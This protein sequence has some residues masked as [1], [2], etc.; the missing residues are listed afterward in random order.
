MEAKYRLITLGCKVNQY[1]TQVVR[2]VLEATGLRAARPGEDADWAIINTCAVTG[3]ALRKSRQAVRRALRDGAARVM[4]IGCGADAD[5]E[6]L[7]SIEG[8][9]A[10][11][12]H[13]EEIRSRVREIVLARL[14]PGSR[15]TTACPS[16]L[17]L[18]RLPAGQI[19]GCKPVPHPA[20]D[21]NEGSIRPMVPTSA[22]GPTADSSDPRVN[23][24]ITR[25][26]PIVKRADEL[27]AQIARFEGRRRAFLKV[28]DGCDAFCSYC[29]IPR[30]RPNLRWKRIDVAVAEAEALVR[31]GHREI[32]LTGV[33]LGAYGRDTAIRKRFQPGPSPLAG[34]V[35]ALA[36]VKGLER[37]R[38]SSLE[39]GDV[40]Q[41]LLDALALH[42]NCVPHLHLPLQSGSPNILRRMN[43]QYSVD[44]FVE[45][46]DR[47]RAALDRPA[48][49]T[50]IIVG[51][52]G[53][54]EAD[55]EATLKVVRHA[56]VCKI[57]TFPFSPR[58]KTA[59]ARWTNEFVPPATV[60]ERLRRLA[61]V[62]AELS[63]AFR[64]QFIGCI[65][66]VIVES[67]AS[68]PRVGRPVA[69]DL[70]VGRADRYFEIHFEAD[71]VSPGDL[72]HVR[73]DRVTS[74]GCHGRLVRPCC[75]APDAL[76]DEPPVAPRRPVIGRALGAIVRSL[77]VAVLLAAPARA[78]ELY[79]AQ[80]GVIEGRVIEETP[81]ALRVETTTGV[82]DVPPG[83][84][85]RRVYGPSR[86]ERYRSLEAAVAEDGFTAA[87]HIEIARWCRENRLE[88]AFREQVAAALKLEPA[89]PEARRLAGYVLLGDVWLKTTPS[90]RDNTIRAGL[91]PVR[92]KDDAH[93][94]EQL[95]AGWYR[96]VRT[97]HDTFLSGSDR[98]ARQTATGRE[99]LL[100][101][102]SPLA[103]P[104]TCRF[105]GAG[106]TST[107]LLLIEFLGAFEED[108]A[109]LNLFALALLDDEPRVRLAAV[110]QL[111]RR[112][113]TGEDTGFKPVPHLRALNLLRLALRCDIDEI[114]RRTAGALGEIGDRA[115]V[116][117]LIL[118]LPT[119]GFKGQRLTLQALITQAQSEYATPTRVP[120]TNSLYEYPAAI[121]LPEFERAVELF[122]AGAG[123]AAGPH[124]S[125]V[126]EALIAITGQNFGF[127]IPAWTLWLKRNPPLE[128]LQP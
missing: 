14:E 73:I 69:S 100:A 84:V 6:R 68:D 118:A 8:V 122:I 113:L 34:L 108:V 27:T 24:S 9:E 62:E 64:R 128:P 40:D 38:L 121:L 21:R 57:H 67:V 26:L 31:A 10:V 61:R 71:D 44:A 92:N 23:R 102:R 79:L 16:G 20:A 77:T 99:Q 7:R 22:Q 74:N 43:R 13:R 59:A 120:L 35:A 29:I 19:T 65:E 96:R 1:E 50:D 72:V 48:I 91:S 18:H 36:R 86:I 98:Q 63:L 95:V 78:D 103:I 2:E 17:M 111:W 119:D 105:L 42:D 47:V 32:I 82:L 56:Q 28:Q 107:R 90:H 5:A 104:A 114:V 85:A 101:L 52:P 127:N 89:H 106:G 12:G 58:E 116:G 81:F 70:C 124:R 49:T 66:R 46:I 83:I 125:E 15:E 94:V 60:K 88:S 33:F 39:P 41:A 75:T 93:I 53:E 76:A 11:F 123:P 45:M 54:T 110:R 115:A 97:I 3:E 30:L 55:F 25:S 4:V 37:L 51:F 80:H 126:Q 112:R 117:D 109:S 87:G